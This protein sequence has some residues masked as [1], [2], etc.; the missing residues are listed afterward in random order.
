MP[1]SQP[2]PGDGPGSQLAPHGRPSSQLALCLAPDSHP[3]NYMLNNYIAQ[4]AE[5]RST[6]DIVLEVS[7]L[8]WN[9]QKA[10]S[11]SQVSGLSNYLRHLEASLAYCLS[12]EINFCG[13]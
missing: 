13:K 12:N 8:A 5:V 7:I 9:L 11:W 10:G 4:K 3:P 1:D 6:L 2:A